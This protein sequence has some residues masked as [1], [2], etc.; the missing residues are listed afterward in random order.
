MN[1]SEE[2]ILNGN[3]FSDVTTLD[4]NYIGFIYC[5]TNL[6]DGRQYIGKKTLFS[7]RKVQRVVTLKNGTKKKKK[8][9]QKIESDWKNYWSSSK[10]LQE[11]IEK[12]GKESFKREIIKLC[13]TKAEMSYYETKYQLE[14]DVLIQPDRWYNCFA[15]CRI[16]R[17][18]LK[19]LFFK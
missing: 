17:S 8:I 7:T 2:W 19:Y 3:P 10:E 16:N 15:T 1:N 13:K 12:L 14:L 6:I 5:I 4:D 11:D 9:T 18:H